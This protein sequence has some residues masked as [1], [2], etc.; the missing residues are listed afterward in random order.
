VRD[1][2]RKGL[3]VDRAKGYEPLT[4]ASFARSEGVLGVLV[5]LTVRIDPRPTLSAF[6]LP[7][8]T[9]EQALD[10]AEWIAQSVPARFP[11]PANLKL[12]SGSHMRHIR[13]VW[14]DESAREWRARPGALDLGR[15][16]QRRRR[17]ARRLRAALRPA[18]RDRGLPRTARSVGRTG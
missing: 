12:F 6:L 7:F 5:R 13:H 9:R 18:D 4:L 14:E 11:A 3:S 16:R 17:R 2:D 8:E 15:G 1:L 10:A